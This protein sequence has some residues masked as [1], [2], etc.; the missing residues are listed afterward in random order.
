MLCQ[1]PT[2]RKQQYVPCGRKTLKKGNYCSYHKIKIEKV[3]CDDNNCIDKYYSIRKFETLNIAKLKIY[4]DGSYSDKIKSYS[5][6][7]VVLYD[8]EVIYKF[9]EKFNDEK[10]VLLRNVSGEVIGSIKAV[11][12]AINNNYK[13]VEI[14]FDYEGIRSWALGLWN[15]NNDIT[16]NYYTFMQNSMK[17]IDII[18]EI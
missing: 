8:D 1:E 5:Y 6:G 4:V 10:G 12:Y 17:I 13:K 14:L 11:E 18:F 3:N 7:M 9:S 15:R 16:R 2:K